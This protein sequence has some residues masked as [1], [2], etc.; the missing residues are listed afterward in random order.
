MVGEQV[1]FSLKIIV[2]S[3]KKYYR[4]KPF[5]LSSFLNCVPSL[6]VSDLAVP[7]GLLNL[8]A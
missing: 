5:L 8:Q 6:T 7:T 4:K 1:C 3:K 2:R